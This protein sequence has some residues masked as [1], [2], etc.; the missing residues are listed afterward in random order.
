MREKE[1]Y[2][3]CET[4]D[5]GEWIFDVMLNNMRNMLCMVGGGGGAKE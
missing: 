2:V 3:K 1:E 4:D 5:V